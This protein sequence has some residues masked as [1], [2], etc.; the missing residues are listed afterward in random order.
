[1]TM[2]GRPR[3][4]DEK[5]KAVRLL[6]D[7][8]SYGAAAATLVPIPGSELVAI[9]PIHVGM[10][11]GIGRHYGH[12]VT[13]AEAGRLVARIGAVIGVSWLGTRAISLAA[14]TF[15]PFIGGLAM[16]PLMFVS[17]RALGKVVQ[18]WYRRGGMKDE[19]IREV[20]KAEAVKAREAFDP[21]RARAEADRRRAEP[22]TE[23]GWQPEEDEITQ[24]LRRL[25][26]IWA[27]GLISDDEYAAKKAE[28]LETL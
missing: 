9:L 14:K 1:M 4:Q 15:L 13:D 22:S 2:R 17:T 12:T 20:Y 23:D 5:D 16:A 19:E 26:N 25:A 6:I 7:G 10:V 21:K 27:Q 8:C 28:I 24:R 11:V 18:A 3:R